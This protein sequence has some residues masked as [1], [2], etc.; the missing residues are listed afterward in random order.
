MHR[1]LLSTLIEDMSWPFRNHAC[2]TQNNKQE[3]QPCTYTL[4]FFLQHRGLRINQVTAEQMERQ[5]SCNGPTDIVTKS[6]RSYS[7]IIN[8]LVSHDPQ[9]LHDEIMHIILKIIVLVVTWTCLWTFSSKQIHRN[10]TSWR[11]L[12]CIHKLKLPNPLECHRHDFLN[13]TVTWIQASKH[14][15]ITIWNTWTYQHDI[16][17]PSVILKELLVFNFPKLQHQIFESH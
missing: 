1:L 16:I 10:A 15:N 2:W 3:L 5:L 4:P 12:P 6:L 9:N 7:R 11:H 13:I 17:I 8:T 14:N